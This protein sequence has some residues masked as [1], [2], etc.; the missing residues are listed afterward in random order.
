M[1]SELTV[2]NS[3]LEGIVACIDQKETELMMQ[4]ETLDNTITGARRE[5]GTF[6]NYGTERMLNV[7]GILFFADPEQ[8]AKEENPWSKHANWGRELDIMIKATG[9]D[10]YVQGWQKAK[11]HLTRIDKI[12]E[13]VFSGWKGNQDLMARL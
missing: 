9:S 8:Y 1:K 2:M 11:T 4:G 13:A 7:L 3:I 10:D 12:E 6:S 5:I